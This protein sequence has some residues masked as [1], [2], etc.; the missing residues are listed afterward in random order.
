MIYSCT[1]IIT[2]SAFQGP[3]LERLPFRSG[4]KSFG[5][6]P[7]FPVFLIQREFTCVFDAFGITRYDV[8]FFRFTVNPLW[9][10]AVEYLR[11]YAFLAIMPGGQFLRERER[12]LGIPCRIF[13][14]A[15]LVVA[16]TFLC[17]VFGMP[18]SKLCW[19]LF[20]FDAMVHDLLLYDAHD[21]YYASTDILEDICAN[22]STWAPLEPGLPVRQ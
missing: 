7:G 14:V 17:D 6:L 13:L 21:S 3:C 1:T 15:R 12:M 11:V 22:F 8:P 20:L 4:P 5:P 2:H 10:T 16:D 18:H 9:R 19:V